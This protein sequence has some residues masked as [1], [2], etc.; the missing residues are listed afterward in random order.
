MFPGTSVFM[1]SQGLG[2]SDS[3]TEV[4]F[5]LFQDAL[6][7]SQFLLTSLVLFLSQNL[8]LSSLPVCIFSLHLFPSNSGN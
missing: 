5:A 8:T 3:S 4:V 2:F 7:V 1:T 6:L